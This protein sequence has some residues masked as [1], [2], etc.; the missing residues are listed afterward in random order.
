MPN[1]NQYP[2]YF[3]LGFVLMAL[4]VGG[5]LVLLDLGKIDVELWNIFKISSK[6]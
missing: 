6:I 5:I 3:T 1:Q 4:F 2:I